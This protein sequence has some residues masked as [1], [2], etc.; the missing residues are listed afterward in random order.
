MSE[1]RDPRL[2][3]D[4]RGDITAFVVWALKPG[5]PTIVAVCT[6]EGLCERYRSVAEVH[7]RATFYVEPI[8]LDHAFGRRDVQSAI[9]AA[10][11]K[12][13]RHEAR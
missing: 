9:Y 11:T 12:G 5:Q 13:D 7:H 1:Q 3:Y 6:S 8:T 10:A 4:D 2:Q